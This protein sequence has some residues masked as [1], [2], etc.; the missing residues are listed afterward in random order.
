MYIIDLKQAYKVCKNLKS[1]MAVILGVTNHN[2][3]HAAIN[4]STNYYNAVP[5]IELIT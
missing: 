3:N 2:D 4:P 1:K 5:Y